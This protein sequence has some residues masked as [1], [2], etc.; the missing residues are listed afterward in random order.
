MN[1]TINEVVDV[2]LANSTPLSMH[3]RNR[4]YKITKV[5]LRHDFLEG[6]TLMHVFSVLSG[7][8]FLKLKLDTKHLEW[9]L[10][11]ISEEV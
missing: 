2:V 4:D 3:W 7:T 8:L 1:Q 6:K 11:E 10:L 5:G 9:K